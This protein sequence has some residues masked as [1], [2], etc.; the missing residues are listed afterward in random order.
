LFFQDAS[1]SS[2]GAH[3]PLAVSRITAGG[4]T[5]LNILFG[6]DVEIDFG[7]G[8]AWHQ[9]RYKIKYEQLRFL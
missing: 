6:V 5:I 9:R 1:I 8:E 7:T 3:W 2:L 4:P